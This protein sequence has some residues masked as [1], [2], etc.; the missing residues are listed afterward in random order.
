M[1]KQPGP[2]LPRTLADT[3]I[4]VAIGFPGVAQHPELPEVGLERIASE[5]RPYGCNAIGGIRA[6]GH[7]RADAGGLFEPGN[8]IATMTGQADGTARLH[9]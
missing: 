3:R 5:K 2:W 4:S 9:G 6:R 7:E 8:G 1:R